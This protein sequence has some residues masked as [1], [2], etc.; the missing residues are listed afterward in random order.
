[1]ARL[2]D[3]VVSA[4]LRVADVVHVDGEAARWWNKRKRPGE[5]AMFKGWYWTCGPREAGPFPNRSAAIRDAYYRIV[6]RADPPG[7]ADA[8]ARG[9]RVPRPKVTHRP[10]PVLR[11]AGKKRGVGRPRREEYYGVGR[12]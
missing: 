7:A 11:D 9:D 8:T 10:V 5:S 4:A 12:A 2:K 1:M 3:A 6:L